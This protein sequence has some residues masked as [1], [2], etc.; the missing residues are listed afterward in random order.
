VTWPTVPNKLPVVSEERKYRVPARDDLVM[1][2]DRS[3]NVPEVLDR[4]VRYAVAQ[5]QSMIDLGQHFTARAMVGT[6]SLRLYRQ[7][8]LGRAWRDGVPGLLRVGILVGFHFYVWAAFW[9]LSGARRTPEDD[10]YVRRLG[11]GLEVLRRTHAAGMLPV[12]V[13]RR[14]LGR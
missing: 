14:L 9:Q 7:L 11:R 2:H 5:A 12:R 1:V 13:I 6:L 3:R 8:V 4:S 10:R